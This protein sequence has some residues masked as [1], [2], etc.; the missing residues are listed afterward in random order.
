MQ[1]G[2]ALKKTC[3]SCNLAVA[4]ARVPDCSR[5]GPALRSVEA[6][7]QVA[8]PHLAM[9]HDMRLQRVNVLLQLI[10][11]VNQLLIA[12]VVFFL[13]LGQRS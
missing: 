2:A 4:P 11:L 8:S 10:H 1:A 5:T 3:S 12:L 7:C 9:C 6:F 13:A